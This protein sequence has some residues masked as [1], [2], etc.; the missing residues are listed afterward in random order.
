MKKCMNCRQPLRGRGRPVAWHAHCLPCAAL[1]ADQMEPIESVAR[2]G[3]KPIQIMRCRWCGAERTCPVGWATRCHL[4]LDDRTSADATAT[5]LG[6]REATQLLAVT[7]LIGVLAQFEQPGWTVIAGDLLGLPWTDDQYARNS[8]GTW[9]RHDACGRIQVMSRG[10]DECAACP[11]EP[12]S[13]THRARADDTHLL[14]LVRYRDFVKFG[15]G[16]HGRVRHHLRLGATPVQVLTARHAEVHVAE[17]AL[18]RRH[19]TDVL[20]GITGVP[21]SFGAGTEVLPLRLSPDL[22]AFLRQGED[23]TRHFR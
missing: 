5:G 10:R 12:G 14:Y 3:G 17:L 8:H 7:T 22:A 2:P 4:C 15:R 19:V 6:A 21:E 20:R 13:R 16:Y 9:G 1:V 18:K 11:P 23:V